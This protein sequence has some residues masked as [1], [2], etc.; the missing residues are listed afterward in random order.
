MVNDEGWKVF[1]EHSTV[2]EF[3]GV[4]GLC[5]KLGIT[6]DECRHQ[7]FAQFER[8]KREFSQDEQRSFNIVVYPLPTLED[9]DMP[10]VGPAHIHFRRYVYRQGYLIILTDATSGRT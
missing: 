2:L 9:A 3:G 6:E 10:A 7:V 1:K 8:I 5:K 4:S